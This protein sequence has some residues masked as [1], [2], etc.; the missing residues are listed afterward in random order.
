MSLKTNLL[1]VFFLPVLCFAQNF[2]L[3]IPD[4]RKIENTR[5]EGKYHN[6]DIYTYLML[7][8]KPVS[9]KI[10][11]KYLDFPDYNMCSFAQNFEYGITYFTDSCIEAGGEIVRVTFPKIPKE[12]LTAWIEKI[13]NNNET[14]KNYW[15]KDKLSYVPEGEGAGCHYK[16]IEGENKWT[17]E[18]YCGC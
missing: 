8:Y 9:E 1:V 17:V 5:T 18:V 14:I 2:E 6:E 16:I 12:E 10:D 3:K 7:N 15:S 13:Y 11:I 4:I